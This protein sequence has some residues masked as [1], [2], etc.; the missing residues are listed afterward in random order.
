MQQRSKPDD[1]VN[2]IGIDGSTQW[3]I[4][5]AQAFGTGNNIWLKAKN[6]L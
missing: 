5:R 1:L 3:K 6:I 2:F 4:T